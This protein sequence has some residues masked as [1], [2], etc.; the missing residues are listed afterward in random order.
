MSS[1]S[2]VVE[3]TISESASLG[4]IRAAANESRKSG[5]LGA[6]VVALSPLLG[7]EVEGE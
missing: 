7:C 6:S 4:R 5:S 2:P 3:D 1:D